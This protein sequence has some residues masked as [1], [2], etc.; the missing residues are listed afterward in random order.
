MYEENLSPLPPGDATVVFADQLGEVARCGHQAPAPVTP[1]SVV[2]WAEVENQPRFAE[3]CRRLLLPGSRIEGL[4]YLRQ[5]ATLA[6][7]GEACLICFNHRSNFDVPT[8]LALLQ[9]A[10]EVELFDRIVW[11]SGRKLEEDTGLTRALVHC[12]N[13]VVVTPH[14]WFAQ[15]HLEEEY[16]AARRVNIAAER[17]MIRLR[18]Q[19]WMFALFPAGTRSRPSDDSTHE[20]IE[21]TDGYLRLFDHLV[22]GSISGCTLPVTKDYDFTHETPRLDRMVYSF[23]SVQRTADYRAAAAARFPDLEQRAASAQAIMEDIE[24]L[25][26]DD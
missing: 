7:R 23:G 26:P 19:N 1:E 24:S 17:V 11:V 13:R 18:Q 15:Q 16:H 21:E 4:T 14:T 9:D 3:I 10:E 20:A 6:G 5:L 2:R 12:F 25:Q 22:L 8:L